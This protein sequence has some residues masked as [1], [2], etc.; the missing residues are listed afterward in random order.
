VRSIAL[1]LVLA[2]ASLAYADIAGVVP[3]KLV[4]IDKIAASGKAK[5][6]FVARDAGVHKGAGLD[7]ADIAT[8]LE[9]TWG[10]TR[11]TF[12]MPAG[13]HDGTSGWVSNNAAVAKYV[14]AGA[15]TTPGDAVKVSIV[16]P[17][18]LLK[19]V[20]KGL[21]DDSA[22]DLFEVPSGDIAAC[23]TITNGT[24][25]HRFGAR[26]PA[27]SCAYREIA[28]GAGR[29]LVCS[30]GGVPDPSCG[31]SC[32]PELPPNAVAPTVLSDTG[33]FDDIVTKTV[34]P[35]AHLYA[36]QFQLWADGAAK[37]RWIYLPKCAQID[38]TDMDVWSFPVGTRLW[39]QFDLGGELLE[40]RMIHRFGPGANDFLYAVYEWNVGSTEATLVTGGVEDVKGTEHDIPATTDCQRCHGPFAGGGGQPSRYLGFSA[41]QLSH[42]GPGVTM[43]SLSADG[44]LTTPAP[45]GFTVPGTATEQ[46]ALGYLHANCGNCHNATADGIGYLGMEMRVRTTDATVGATGAYT[47][48]VNQPVISFL[49]QGCDYRVAGGDTAA[50]CVH[51]RMSERGSDAMGN[52]DQ[53]PPLASDVV[54]ASGLATIAAWIM[55]LP[56]PPP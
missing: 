35:Y 5:A 31:A 11:G 50:S 38:T 53:M 20:A 15:G 17:G 32:A 45:A 13:A 7:T 49:G 56:A 51:L 47:T 40:T 22:L 6:I 12:A 48:V 29:K 3:A 4:V 16:K 25:V 46:A 10:T 43:A 21:G 41:I 26:W 54:D 30:G 39:K 28:G 18:Q 34:A 2:T 37:N 33:L 24:E 52:P 44:L 9:V 19:V 14:N 55:G 42:T 27:A 8:Q 36:P 1:I 23:Y